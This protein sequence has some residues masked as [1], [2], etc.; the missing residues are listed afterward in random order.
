MSVGATDEKPQLRRTSSTGKSSKK[1]ISATT[2]AARG[3]ADS[4]YIRETSNL[5]DNNI[6]LRDFAYGVSILTMI[7]M[8]MLLWG[9]LCAILCAAAR[10]A[11]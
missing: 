1:K 8:T 6:G 4:G 5:Q 11:N 3:D 9:K 2:V 7:L 10:A